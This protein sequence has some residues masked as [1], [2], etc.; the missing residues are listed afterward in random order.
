MRPG[1]KAWV[2]LRDAPPHLVEP[3]HKAWAAGRTGQVGCDEIRL[4]ET[5]EALLASRASQLG[6]IS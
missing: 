6:R 2:Q 1:S 5:G 3:L 4:S